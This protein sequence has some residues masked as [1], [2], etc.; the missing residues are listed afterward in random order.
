MTCSE[1]GARIT[2]SKKRKLNKT[3]GKIEEYTYYHCTKRKK[4]IDCHAEP[5]TLTKLEENINKIIES[6]LIDPEFYQLGL[7]TLK[8]MH[9]LE[10]GK[11]QQ[12]FETQQRNVEDTQ[13]KLDR[14]LTYLLD[15]TISREQYNI[16][17]RELEESL[18][19][20]K[21][22]LG[23]TEKRATNWREL[24]E[25]VLHFS[26]L[27][28]EAL[29]HGDTKIKREILSGL[30]W[31]HRIESKKLFINLHS[32]FNVLKNGEKDLLP[33]I[34]ALELDKIVDTQERIEA[35][36]SIRPKLCVERDS[37]PRCQLRREIYSLLE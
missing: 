15:G 12:I 7:E 18:T 34:K 17:K 23:E 9:G 4:Y 28:M 16:Q 24:T 33:E 29:K 35:F 32:W 19:K 22:K 36:A 6:N 13:K 5:I 11:R 21:N 37:N 14:A 30:G 27:S 26:T 20:E 25:N 3:T 2:A 10:T 8:E 31:N 1:C